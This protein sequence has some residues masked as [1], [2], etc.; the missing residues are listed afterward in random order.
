MD[1]SHSLRLIAPE[2]LLTVAGLILLLVAGWAGDKAS[3]LISVLSVAALVGA[4]LAIAQQL[5][6]GR[7]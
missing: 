1:W 6:A 7:G 4:A 5:Q 3:R 2:E